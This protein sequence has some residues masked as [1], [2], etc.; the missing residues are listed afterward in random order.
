MRVS[1]ATPS[2]QIPI[3]IVFGVLN[4]ACRIVI[5]LEQ[6]PA[7]GRYL[8]FQPRV[9]SGKRVENRNAQPVDQSK[10]NTDHLERS[11]LGQLVSRILDLRDSD[12]CEPTPGRAERSLRRQLLCHARGHRRYFRGDGFLYRRLSPLEVCALPVTGTSC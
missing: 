6:K 12:H 2:Y 1:D 8:Q 7:Y 11:E 5:L 9:R 4:V 10:G 3:R